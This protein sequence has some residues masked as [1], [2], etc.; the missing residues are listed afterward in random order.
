MAATIIAL[1]RAKVEVE[2]TRASAVVRVAVAAGPEA[3]VR[4]THIAAVVAVAEGGMTIGEAVA[5]PAKV[6]SPQRST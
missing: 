6:V 2:T 3:Q 4:A 1:A 5:A